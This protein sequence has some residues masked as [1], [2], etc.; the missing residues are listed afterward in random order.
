MGSASR[1]PASQS[2][3]SIL[4]ARRARCGS[5]YPGPAA[6]THGETKAVALANAWIGGFGKDRETGLDLLDLLRYA[7]KGRTRSGRTR[8]RP[9][10]TIKARPPAK[11]R[12]TAAAASPRRDT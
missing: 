12:R 11:A 6:R 1:S 5:L 2:P 4:F 8:S 9:L 10:T 3:V 7:R